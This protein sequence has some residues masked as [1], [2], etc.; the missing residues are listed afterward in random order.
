[1]AGYLDPPR[2][3]SMTPAAWFALRARSGL[4]GSA[5]RPPESPRVQGRWYSPQ[6]PWVSGSLP[7]PLVPMRRGLTATV[8]GPGDPGLSPALPV[9]QARRHLAAA[10]GFRSGKCESD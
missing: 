1:M 5:L 3:S 6:A 2:L 9:L 7:P 4:S 10:P 8:P